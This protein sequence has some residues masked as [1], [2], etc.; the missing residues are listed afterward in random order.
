MPPLYTLSD[1]KLRPRQLKQRH[2]SIHIPSVNVENKNYIMAFR[3]RRFLQFVKD[4]SKHE[5]HVAAVNFD[6]ILEY[7]SVYKHDLMI[8]NDMSC[9]IATKKSHLNS[10]VFDNTGLIMYNKDF[11]I[12]T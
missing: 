3:D 10:M 2:L 8:V 4:Y 1:H 11:V 6:E 12:G 5:Y 7:S 9:D